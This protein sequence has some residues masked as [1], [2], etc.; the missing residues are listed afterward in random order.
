MGKK[1]YNISQGIIQDDSPEYVEWLPPLVVRGE[2]GQV[3][4]EVRE[5]G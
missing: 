2:Q 3:R 5:R 4:I 1:L